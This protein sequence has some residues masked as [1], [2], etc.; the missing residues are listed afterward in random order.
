MALKLTVDTLGDAV[1]RALGPR[2]VALLLYGSTA[3]GT[4][5]PDRSDVN[6]LLICD[7]VDQ[8]LFDALTPLV[9]VWIRAGHPAPVILPEREWRESSG[10]LPIRY[11]E[12][13]EAHRLVP[14]PHPLRRLPVER[15][16]V[17]APPRP[18]DLA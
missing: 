1:T 7:G 2:L 11:Q 18:Q 10:A 16:H 12:L 13:R 6:T 9:R 15:R 17:A 4:H 14:G 3:R 5:V 8:A